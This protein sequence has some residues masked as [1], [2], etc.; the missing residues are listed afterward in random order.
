[1]IANPQQA[2][3]NPFLMTPAMFN[4]MN[5]AAMVPMD[6]HESDSEVPPTGTASGSGDGA[7]AS[8]PVGIEGNA[9]AAA[10]PSEPEDP[11]QAAAAAAMLQLAQHRAELYQNQGR[12]DQRINRGQ[13]SLA[14]LGRVWVSV[15]SVDGCVSGAMV[16]HTG[17]TQKHVSKYGMM[18]CIGRGFV[19]I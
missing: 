7:A 1:M 17:S 15:V 3:M 16:Q 10:R 19:F 11:G 6:D 8:A 13:S 2:M 18:S 4:A 14:S 9:A 12:D 5:A